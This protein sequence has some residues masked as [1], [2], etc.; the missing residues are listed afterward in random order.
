MRSSLLAP[1]PT[2]SLHRSIP[3]G[4]QHTN[5]LPIKGTRAQT[6][7][8]KH[9]PRETQPTGYPTNWLHPPVY[10]LT[11]PPTV[12]V[13]LLQISGDE[14]GQ[15]RD[16][17]PRGVCGRRR[18]GAWLPSPHSPLSGMLCTHSGVSLSDPNRHQFSDLLHKPSRGASRVL[19]CRTLKMVLTIFTPKLFLFQ[20]HEW[21]QAVT[22]AG[23]GCTAT[24]ASLLFCCFCV[25]E[26]L[27]FWGGA[28]SVLHHHIS[29]CSLLSYPMLIGCWLCACTPMLSMTNDPIRVTLEAWRPSRPSASSP[30]QPASYD[31]R[32]LRK[33]LLVDPSAGK[34]RTSTASRAV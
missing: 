12:R 13:W 22:A 11:P 20:D 8:K 18:A 5:K 19:T 29:M 31:G 27:G 4:S 17:S 24:L 3:Q 34:G 6:L 26:G 33:L 23:T 10:R 30:P 32:K 1:P 28:L 9:N 25:G 14:A 7:A 16:L 15:H 21:R 2:R